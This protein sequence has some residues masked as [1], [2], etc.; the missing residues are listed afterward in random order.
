MNIIEAT[1]SYE[2]WMRSCTT[3]VEPHLRSKH[4]QMKDDLFCFFRG[5]FYR[6]A[7][8]FP[9]LCP[10]LRGDPEIVAVGDL[11]V[12][13]F[14]TWR[15]S[16]GR[17]CW[18]VDDFD[19]SYPLPFS[20][21]LV[22]LATSLKIVDDS[23]ALTSKFKAGCEIFL[24]AYRET[25][26]QGGRPIVL[27]EHESSMEK[28]GIAAIKPPKDFWSKL[29]DRPAVKR[30]IPSDARTALE[31]MMPAKL[32]GKNRPAGSWNGKPGPAKVRRHRAVE[33]RLHRTGSESHGS[34]RMCLARW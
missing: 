19:E 3:I 32:D 8:L 22:R 30:G 28:L 31:K 24:E 26:K 15:D 12:S 2:H 29:L 7:Q 6:W 20:N 9:E 17:L 5:S 23:G 25:L 27:A 1:T 14:G 16:E 10:D 4:A 13:S 33:W 34:L 18:G 11:H 21:D